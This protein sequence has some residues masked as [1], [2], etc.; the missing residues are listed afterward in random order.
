MIYSTSSTSQISGVKGE[1][2]HV[3]P[4]VTGGLFE[5]RVMVYFL[6]QGNFFFLQTISMI[7]YLLTL[8]PGHS[9]WGGVGVGVG[10]GRGRGQGG[11]G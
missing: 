7:M 8:R 2:R 1:P 9:L 4:R 11:Q 5:Y 6:E 10:K 3:R